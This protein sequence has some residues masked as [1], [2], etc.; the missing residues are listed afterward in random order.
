[1]AT[2]ATPLGFLSLSAEVRNMIYRL[3][4]CHPSPAGLQGRLDWGAQLLRTC[5]QIHAEA[6]PILYGENIFE[7]EIYNTWGPHFGNVHY[8]AVLEDRRCSGTASTAQQ[9]LQRFSITVRYTEYH[10][11]EPMRNEVRR[12][13]RRLQQLPIA[14]IDF[15]ELKC[16]LDCDNENNEINWRDPCWDDYDV[17]GSADEC[18]GVLR[19]WLSRLRNVKEA[20]IVGM[21]GKDAEVLK[22]RW[23]S[24][25]QSHVPET[26]HLTDR[27]KA[28]EKHVHSLG[29]CKDYLQAALLA[30]ENDN[31]DGFKVYSKGIMEGVRQLWEGLSQEELLWDDQSET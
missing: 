4:L 31:E 9:H 17:D 29:F 14:A 11:L 19:T 24:Q 27:Y 7:I 22:A 25:G 23:Q 12:L 2:D 3:V 5:R 13:V 10:K 30:T 20:V 15:L 26:P 6:L 18:V 16:H 21:E 28:L 1:M 8:P